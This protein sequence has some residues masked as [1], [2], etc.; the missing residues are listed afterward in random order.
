MKIKKKKFV[1]GT[2][3][4]TCSLAIVSSITSTFA[5]YS[6][7]TKNGLALS[8]IL[9]GKTEFLQVRVN[10]GEWKTSLTADE[11][12]AQSE[13]DGYSAK[14]LVPVTQ[15]LG[16]DSSGSG[17]A[18]EIGEDCG[19]Y[20]SPSY[21]I[22]KSSKSGIKNDEGKYGFFKARLQFRC[23]DPTAKSTTGYKKMIYISFLDVKA[24]TQTKDVTSAIRMN[25]NQGS[26]YNYN[27]APAFNE[28][29]VFNLT[30]PLKLAGGDS[31]DAGV[32][33]TG[34]A[35]SVNATWRPYIEGYDKPGDQKEVTYG[36][37]D[38]AQL[39][40][41]GKTSTVSTFTDG[42]ISSKKIPIAETPES[43]SP[44]DVN[45]VIWLDGWDS[46]I[47]NDNISAEFAFG[48]Q[49]EIEKIA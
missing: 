29:K 17:A 37:L 4:T 45:L 1:L 22:P 28:D 18:L 8:G 5:W 35:G 24:I 19:F 49:F 21:L 32:V 23:I 25:I 27:I 11:I 40:C 48:I 36:N 34:S 31:N 41:L 3:L 39:K 20:G 47:N 43:G 42:I 7:N 26:N 33:V 38:G 44:I 16:L 2:L 14:N 10:G 30:G 9:T 46:S 6:Y 13:L 12:A 15:P